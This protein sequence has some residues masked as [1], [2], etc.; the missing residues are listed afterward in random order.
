MP[1]DVYGP[2]I[3]SDGTVAYVA[4]GYSFSAGGT[5]TQLVR[6]NP[7]SNTWTPLAPVPDLNNAMASGVYA[8]N[9]NK[10]FVFG[11]NNPT[12]ATVVNTTRIYDPV[13]GTWS[14]GA[15]MPDVRAFMGSGYYNGKIYLV[16]GYT[17]GNVDPAFGQ[18]WEYD[19]VLNTWNTSRASMPA[20]LGGPGFGII[21]GH[22]YIAGGRNLAN[23]NLNTLYDYDIAANTWTPR[24]NLPV[25]VNVPASGVANNLLYIMGGGNPFLVGD[26]PS[27]TNITQVYNP[28][29]NTWSSGPALLQNLSFPGGTAIGTKLLVAGGYNGSTTVA[30][31]EVLDVGGGCP[32]PTP[33]V[34]PTVTPTPSCTPGY[35][36][37]S[38]T[39]AAIVPGTVDTGNHTDDGTTNITLPFTYNLYGQP[40]TTANVSS[41]GNLQ[42]V[43]N[44]NALTNACPLPSA[45]FDFAVMPHWDDMRTDQVGTGCTAYGGVG[46]G[47][48]TS[49]TGVAPNRI[50]NIEWRTV[51]FGANTTRANFEARLYEGQNRFD[52]IYGET[53]QNGN[54]ASVGVQRDTG[55]QFTEY[56]CNTPTLT[57]G[58]QLAFTLGV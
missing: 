23:N 9:V 15:V 13:A 37:A 49:V 19:P 30:A 39:G 26:A 46:C 35:T 31:A 55:S 56:E 2:A 20:T 22:I 32:T 21:N 3:S 52:F 29:T 5:V 36:F 11:G 57:S 53:A 43:S 44:S 28:A 18:V 6:Y 38:S 7:V 33:T 51:Y 42:F 40:F 24:A 47:I 41:N 17:T 45:Q 48:F 1:T 16:G 34:T 12:T 10:F 25:G 27:T 50:F 8:P 58:Q 54:S 4:G 14:A